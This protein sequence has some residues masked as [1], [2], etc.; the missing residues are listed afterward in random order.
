MAET[1]R[2]AV[3]Y[4]HPIPTII[5]VMVAVTIGFVLVGPLIGVLASL[6]FYEGGGLTDLLDA[7]QAPL[8][9]PDIKIPVY[10]LQGFATL[11]GLIITPIILLR[12]LKKFGALFP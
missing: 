4:L 3:S 8:E 1:D 2:I 7:L 5:L 12:F 9:S 10:V 6:P 11:V